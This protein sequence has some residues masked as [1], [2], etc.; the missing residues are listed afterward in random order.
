[1]KDL[2]RIATSKVISTK[3]NDYKEARKSLKP[4]DYDVDTTV[5]ITG[6]IRVAEDLDSAA[7][8]SL[9]NKE[10]VIL[11][12]HHAGVTREASV[13]LI[14]NLADDYL[15]EWTSSK[16]DKDNAKKL[17]KSKIAEIDPE[18]KIASIFDGLKDRIPR[19]RKSGPVTWKGTV[20]EIGLSEVTEIEVA[21]PAS[22]DTA[23]ELEV[24][25][26]SVA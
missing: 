21:A 17:R 22:G 15:S 7:T 25:E 3:K 26:E 19:I 2:T 13:R 20:E 6:R 16:E 9:L 8:A 11:L 18:G 5:R 1:M 4:G 23:V 10:F 12:L 14:E 24:A